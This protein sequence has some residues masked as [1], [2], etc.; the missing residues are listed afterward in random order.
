ML[1]LCVVLVF[2]GGISLDLW[3]VFNE[4]RALAGLVDAAAVAGASGIDVARF[5]ESGAVALDPRLAEDLARANVATQT[6]T[7]SLTDVAV[8]ANPESITV[9]GTGMVEPTLLRVLVPADAF[10]IEVSATVE[11]RRSS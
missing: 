5:R 2:V 10:R 9:T 11:P 4:R 6:D 3:R 7:R 8:A 1:G